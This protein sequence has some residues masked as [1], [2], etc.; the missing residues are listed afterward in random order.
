[1]ATA[2]CIYGRKSQTL[3]DKWSGHFR[4]CFWFCFLRL[5]NVFSALLVNPSAMQSA[6][7]INSNYSKRLA[8]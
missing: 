7:R 5:G 4:I 2:F 3:V 8:E 1:M 6:G